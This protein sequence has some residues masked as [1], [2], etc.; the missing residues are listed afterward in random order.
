MTPNKSSRGRPKGTGLNDGA[1]LRAI[2]GLM[3][4]NPDL[5][6]TT[7][8]K[9]LGI[10]DPSVIRRLRDKFAV[11]ETQLIADIT[12]QLPLFAPALAAV[13]AAPEPAIAAAQA[14]AAVAT[15]PSARV[16]P[17][18]S[19]RA[20]RKSAPVLLSGVR[21]AP[22]PPSVTPTSE[23]Q[24]TAA[25]VPLPRAPRL[26]LVPAPSE[27]QLPAWLGMGLSLYVLSAESQY[28]VVGSFFKW[29]LLTAALKS[30]VA[31]TEMAVAMTLPAA[32]RANPTG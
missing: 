22:L 6:P 19:A 17:L 24:R 27:T 11:V 31:F 10:T 4:S 21:P 26:A 30:H 9:T 3:A 28:A 29:P 25:I 32:A 12:P 2:A 1:Q 13:N 8:I 20:E 16:L 23:P 7:A 5:R 15:R 14:I 18:A